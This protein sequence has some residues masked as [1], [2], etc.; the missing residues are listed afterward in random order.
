MAWVG[1]ASV[2]AREA[3][4]MPG[5][6]SSGSDLRASAW[7]TALAY[8]AAAFD[9]AARE[10]AVGSGT[11]RA[12]QVLKKCSASLIHGGGMPWRPWCEVSL[13]VM[14]AMRAAGEFW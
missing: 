5:G 8:A 12:A 4:A 13:A 14:D 1:M 11:P 2:G 9:A 7:Q 3:K 6:R 10:V